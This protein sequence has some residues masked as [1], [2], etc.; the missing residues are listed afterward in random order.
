MP[1][2]GALTRGQG[3]ALIPPQGSEVSYLDTLMPL[4]NLQRAAR[5]KFFKC[6]S[7]HVIPPLKTLQCPSIVL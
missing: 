7:D 4:Y 6:N 5:V 1:F 2:L 3:L